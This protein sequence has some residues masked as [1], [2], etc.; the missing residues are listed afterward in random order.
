MNGGI[1][2]HVIRGN[3][4]FFSGGLSG[5]ACGPRPALA[6]LGCRGAAGMGASSVQGCWGSP[7]LF[8]YMKKFME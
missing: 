8:D 5:L 3:L 7:E 1:L 6:C 2:Y 4:A